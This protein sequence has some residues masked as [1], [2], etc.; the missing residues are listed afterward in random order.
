[1]LERMIALSRSRPPHAE[2]AAGRSGRGQIALCLLV[3]VLSL[4]S[5]AP[6]MTSGTEL[7][8]IRNALSLGEAL[9]PDFDWVP[10]QRPA[11]FL[12]ETVAPAPIF[13]RVAG[14]LGLA[15]LPDDWERALAI[16]RHLLGSA[17]VLSGGAI[18]ADLPTTYQRITQRGDGYCGD[19]VRAFHAL[20]HAAG[21]TTRSWAFAFDRFGGHGHVWVELWNRQ[22][23]R[24]QLVDIFDN[25]Y[26]TLADGAPLSALQFRRALLAK[27]PGLR[28]NPLYAGAR[29]GFEIEAKAWDYFRR[30]ADQWY[31]VWGDNVN[32]QDQAAMVRAL[33]GVSRALEQLGGIVQGVQ[34][35]I[36]ILPTPTNQALAQDMRWLRWHLL[37]VALVVFAALAAAAG[38]V[39]W[40]RVEAPSV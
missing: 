32:S 2:A 34:P 8:R 11:D 19:F 4:L 7:V 26:F 23:Q 18:Q 9:N 38:L 15:A 37:G 24:W 1:M 25:F 29:P 30:G 28:L 14:E 13:L 31:L 27:T 5:L 35:D 22:Q 33:S 3:A 20:A 16:S 10:P 12:S 36:R 39:L 40:R 21:M 17:P 6:Y